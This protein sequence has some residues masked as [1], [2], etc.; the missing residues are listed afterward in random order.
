SSDSEDP[1][2]SSEQQAGGPDYSAI[3]ITT[4]MAVGHSRILF[5]I[6]DREGMPVPAESSEVAAY[7]LVPREDSR[8]LKDSVTAQFVSWPTAVGGVFV[9]EV[10]LDA[11]GVYEIDVNA[12]STDG[13]P[14]F[15]QANFIL[16]ETA[17]T[18]EVGSFAP[19]SV[20]HTGAEVDDL[21]HI[22]SSP[23]PDPGLY[24]FSIHE[25]L[26]QGKPLAVVFATPAF[27][28][29]AT[30]G[31]Q[32]GELSKVKDKVGDQA[33]Y[34]HVEVFESPHLLE[35]GRPAG[36]LVPAVDEWG[37]PTEPWTFIIDAQGLVYAKFEQFTTAE[38]IEAKLREIL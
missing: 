26:Q 20:T 28:V 7:F 37:L 34:I 23:E 29:R 21:S 30:C 31:P 3:I 4:D 38:E 14:I 36:G 15:A 17:S 19:A 10:D 13:T 27:C 6:V 1:I 18:P 24:R 12:T 8:E 5:G 35:G 32:V 16:K 9:L 22:T 2:I 25:A 33:N 11:A